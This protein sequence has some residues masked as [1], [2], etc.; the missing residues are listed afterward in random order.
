M[1]ALPFAG[2]V[3][4][5]AC[6]S[7]P[8]PPA[9][10]AQ[11]RLAEA[12]ARGA[13]ATQSA[14]LASAARDYEEAR[15]IARS[16]EDADALA[17]AAVNLSIV[18]QR[19]GREADAH[20]ALAEVLDRP[21]YAYPERRLAQAEL[22]R[23]VL[24]LAGGNPLE[25]A[26]WAQ[27][28]DARCGA[29]ELLP[30]IGN[31]RAQVALD[32]KDFARA[33]ELARAASDSARAKDNRAE[34]GNALRTLGRARLALGDAPAAGAALEQALQIDH[35]LADPRKILA[36]LTELARVESARGDDAKRRAYFDRAIAVGRALD[37]PR[38]VAQLEAEMSNSG[39][40]APRAE[41]ASERK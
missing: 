31:V 26:A 17:A 1:R 27:R 21:R 12:Y 29:C 30:A 14:N 8:P 13:A 11:Q 28:A 33:A 6:A 20:E 5:G 2:I 41:P 24:L 10:A 40:P 22:R 7:A 16:V 37:D 39:R 19:L 4:L 36:D 35:A 15:R 38:A 32:T 23:S 25:A 34:A 18:Y 9:P 3:L